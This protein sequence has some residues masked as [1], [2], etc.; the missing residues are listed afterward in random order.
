[1]FGGIR[2]SVVNV[3]ATATLGPF[4][5]VV[6]LG[7]PIINANVYGE[8]G[9]LGGA[10]VVAALALGSEIL[11]AALQRAVTPRGLRIQRGGT[12]P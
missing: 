9:R 7:D 3:V 10:I 6:T 8:A 2:T 5:G 12:T 11:F 4:V 1:V